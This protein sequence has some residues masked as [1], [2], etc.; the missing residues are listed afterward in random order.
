MWNP[1]KCT[2][3]DHFSNINPQYFCLAAALGLEALLM[4]FRGY[5]FY[6]MENYMIVPTML[7]LGMAFGKKLSPIA[8]RQLWLALGM[9]FWF[10]ITQTLHYIMGLQVRSVGLF[11]SVYLLAFLFA[12][13]SD[14][15]QKQWGLRL[16]AAA[17][18]G[19]ALILVLFTC[20][21]ALELLPGFLLPHVYWD[22]ARL[23]AMWHPNI[24]AVIFMMAIA[25]CLF[26][27]AQ[28]KHRLEKGVTLV[29][30]AVFFFTMALTNSR[31]AIIMTCCII[32]GFL[33]FCIY[34]GSWK[35]FAAGAVAAI[36]SIMV[37]FTTAQTVFQTHND[38]LITKYMQQAE[39]IAAQENLP[40][41]NTSPQD[42]ALKET[43]PLI[44]DQQTGEVTLKTDA[45]QKS[46]AIN[47]PTLNGRT[48]IWQRVLQRLKEDSRLLILGTDNTEALVSEVMGYSLAHAHNAW[49]ETLLYLGLPGLLFALL[50]TGIAA[51]HIWVTF[52]AK[53]STL[54][55][56][57]I[58]MLVLC[59]MGA[60][61][62]EPYLFFTN[63]F[64][65]YTDF[66]Y[67][68]CLGYLV[69]WRSKPHK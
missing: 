14:D 44:I 50:F 32:G 7:F 2:L 51:W 59:L 67:F 28:A 42:T 62:L 12:A 19:A 23:Q 13:L 56:K 9:V 58:A 18:I 4:A 36:V 6:F 60:G 65:H 40:D 57:I 29:L 47:L 30:A 3:W 49:M 54:S 69:C 37:L 35:R 21:L 63:I 34:N 31:T 55:Q 64:Y 17:C 22:G 20:L 11:T 10:F 5:G 68:L 52:W 8:R 46:L 45:G 15:A 41:A 33:F 1:K 61:I 53:T 38:L 24:C 66:I 16:A 26:L 48:T 25:F 27:F 43:I 39:E